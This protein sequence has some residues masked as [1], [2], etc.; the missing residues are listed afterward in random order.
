MIIVG[1]CWLSSNYILYERF[2]RGSNA[3]L[4]TLPHGKHKYLSLVKYIFKFLMKSSRAT[5]L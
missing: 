2:Y 5:V 1:L 3:L 4:M